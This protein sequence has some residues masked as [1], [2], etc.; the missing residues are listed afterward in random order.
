MRQENN[1]LYF[2]GNDGIEFAYTK[3]VF[4]DGITLEI[5]PGEGE[6]FRFERAEEDDDKS[7]V[8][9]VTQT[10]AHLSTYPRKMLKKLVL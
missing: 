9:G 5:T 10:T 2:T 3:I 4:F 6:Y 1:I 7:G 8:N